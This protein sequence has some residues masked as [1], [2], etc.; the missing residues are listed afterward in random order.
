MRSKD[1]KRKMELAKQVRR[2]IGSIIEDGRN[3]LEFMPM[4]RTPSNESI[5]IRVFVV[6]EM[7]PTMFEI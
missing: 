4:R 2:E 1:G 7:M 5:V 3:S 6:R